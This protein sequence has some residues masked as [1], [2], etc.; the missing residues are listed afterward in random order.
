MDSGWHIYILQ[1]AD[2]TLYTGIAKD[3][4]TR[5]RRH[6][7]DLA[8]GPKYTRGRR[9]VNLVWFDVAPDRASAQKREAAIKRLSRSEK[10]RL[11][12]A[13]KDC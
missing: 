11:I 1:C 4:P 6:N 8:G 5:L 9:P 12:G 10:L 13:G 3:I 7:G 2:T